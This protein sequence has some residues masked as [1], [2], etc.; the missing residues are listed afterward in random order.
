M[1]AYQPILRS[2]VDILCFMKKYVHV[3]YTSSE[4]AF[5]NASILANGI[6]CQYLSTTEKSFMLICSDIPVNALH[7]S[8]NKNHI[9]FFISFWAV[10]MVGS[11]LCWLIANWHGQLMLC[12][13][14]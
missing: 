6:S 10:C 14:G 4:A 9:I 8:V 7:M 5:L 12:T 11:L 13:G 1:V 3:A 2:S